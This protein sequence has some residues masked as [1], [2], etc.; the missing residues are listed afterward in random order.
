MV[1]HGI[2]RPRACS[3]CRDRCGSSPER[4]QLMLLD[5]RRPLSL[6]PRLHLFVEVHHCVKGVAIVV[7]PRRLVHLPRLLE[8]DERR[9]GLFSKVPATVGTSS[10]R[11]EQLAGHE[12]LLDL[13][14]TAADAVR[15]GLLLW[16]PGRALGNLVL[17]FFVLVR[18]SGEAAVPGA[19]APSGACPPSEPFPLFAVGRVCVDCP[20]G[21]LGRPCGAAGVGAARGVL[22]PA[23]VHLPRPW[24]RWRRAAPP[25]SRGRAGGG[26]AVLGGRLAP[27][28]TSLNVHASVGMC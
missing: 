5:S 22:L 9:V 23:R 21:R 19:V 8:L 12:E 4:L 2:V 24:S 10:L 25:R 11:R 20:S 18:W 13:Q 1:H 14:N 28:L 7:A 16:E 27:T 26:G 3:V 15:T 17:F 6:V